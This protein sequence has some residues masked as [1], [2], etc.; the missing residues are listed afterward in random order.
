MTATG[1][2]APERVPRAGTR[3]HCTA[4]CLNFTGRLGA[5]PLP[6][7]LRHPRSGA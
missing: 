5:R 7:E 3:T 1:T 2:N 6:A 4:V